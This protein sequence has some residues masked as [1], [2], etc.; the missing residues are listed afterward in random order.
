MSNHTAFGRDQFRP[1]SAKDF[2]QRSRR[3]S[4]WLGLP[5]QRSQELLARIYGYSNYHEL[6]LQLRRAGIPGPFDA[7]DS[8][9]KPT[10][11]PRMLERETR[12]AR[13]VAEF[14]GVEE[15]QLSAHERAVI[16]MGLFQQATLHRSTFNTLLKRIKSSTARRVVTAPTPSHPGLPMPVLDVECAEDEDVEWL[17]TATTAGRFVSGYRLVPQAKDQKLQGQP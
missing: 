14:K 3:L 4:R 2:S 17:W 13:L 11:D 6:R 1:E 12:I 9:L 15:T 8:A 5:Y 10:R 7:P 16:S